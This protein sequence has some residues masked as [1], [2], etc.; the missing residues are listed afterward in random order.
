MMTNM[1]QESKVFLKKAIEAGGIY[2]SPIFP[3][4]PIYHQA[5]KEVS[6]M[7]P[8]GKPCVRKYISFFSTLLAMIIVG[9]GGLI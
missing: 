6:I 5:V 9:I 1:S 3:I 4:G 2:T 7:M 8:Y